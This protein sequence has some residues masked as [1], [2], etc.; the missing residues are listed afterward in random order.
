MAKANMDTKVFGDTVGGFK[1]QLQAASVFLIEAFLVWALNNPNH[2][3]AGELR[4]TQV[5][6]ATSGRHGVSESLIIQ[7]LL[8]KAKEG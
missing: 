6:N 2:T 3:L 7:P 8:M 4:T 1:K 5:A